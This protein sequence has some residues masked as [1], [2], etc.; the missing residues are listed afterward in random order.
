M[1]TCPQGPAKGKTRDIIAAAVGFRS[2]R[3]NDRAKVVWKAAQAGEPKA[4]GLVEQL[5]QGQTTFRLL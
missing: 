1:D 5:D 3:T 2:G 4:L